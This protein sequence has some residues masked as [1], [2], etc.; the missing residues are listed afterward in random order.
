M[1]Q[2]LS[3][4]IPTTDGAAG[5]KPTTS[6]RKSN[7]RVSSTG[8]LRLKVESFRKGQQQQQVGSGDAG[9]QTDISVLKK[10]PAPSK[11]VRKTKKAAVSSSSSG[12]NSTATAASSNELNTTSERS[13]SPDANSS[14]SG[15]SSPSAG[16][17]SGGS[18]GGIVL[19]KESSP[20][21]SK[22]PSPPQSMEEDQPLPKQVKSIF[23]KISFFCV[24]FCTT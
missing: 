24:I 1:K 19:S 11:P 14:T 3:Y 22:V 4:D 10:Q 9:T 8:K 2:I 5:K 17:G 20:C 23:K 15:Y 21:G 16:A 7:S 13:N 18:G 6:L 12:C